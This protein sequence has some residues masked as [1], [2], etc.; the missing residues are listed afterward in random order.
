MVY[1]N[2]SAA[3]WTISSLTLPKTFL[4]QT[5]IQTDSVA[6]LSFF[7]ILRKTYRLGFLKHE[8][9]NKLRQQVAFVLLFHVKIIIFKIDSNYF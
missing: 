9:N 6:R 5:L 1:G 7:A 8:I 2:C 4:N 3:K